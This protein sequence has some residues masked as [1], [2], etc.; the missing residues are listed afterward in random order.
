MAATG[1]HR[2]NTHQAVGV[3]LDAVDHAH[4]QPVMQLIS[5]PLD[6]SSGSCSTALQARSGRRLQVPPSA[7]SMLSGQLLDHV[8][9]HMVE[10][11]RRTLAVSPSRSPGPD[12]VTSLYQSM[13]FMRHSSIDDDPVRRRPTI[14]DTGV[15][16]L[17]GI[18]RIAVAADDEAE[19]T[20]RSTQ[21]L[22]CVSANRIVRF[23]VSVSLS[24]TSA[25][26]EPSAGASAAAGCPTRPEP[27][28]EHQAQ[29]EH[30]GHHQHQD[31]SIVSLFAY[32][33]PFN[34][35]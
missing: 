21:S 30:N 3:H 35:L 11:L 28:D 2:C 31:A 32:F 13:M 18:H 14:G 15:V 5:R 20:A 9:R 34:F 12:S 27:E 23:S 29:N 26:A 7:S 19:G 17:D 10:A 22:N 16:G 24:A 4:C 33:S 8:A 1:F 6:G 25:D